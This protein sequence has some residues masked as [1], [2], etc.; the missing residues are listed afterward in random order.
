MRTIKQNFLERL[1][2]QAEEAEIQKMHALAET[3]THQ[4]I[5]NASNIRGDNAFYSYSSS[6]L[7]EDVKNSIW[8]AIIRIADYYDC[9]LDALAASHI[10]N[11]ISS[12]LIDDIRVLSGVE[13]GVGAYE[14][15]VPGEENN[16]VLV[17]VSE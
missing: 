1:S 2:A 8:D 12:Q 13:H 6:Q 5:K 7:S 4:I 10:A 17:E 11:D 3:L 15:N 14:P 9:G 16:H